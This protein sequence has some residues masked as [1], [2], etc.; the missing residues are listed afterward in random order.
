MAQNKQLLVWIIVFGPIIAL[1]LLSWFASEF[2]EKIWLIPFLL[3]MIPFIA[4]LKLGGYK[5]ISTVVAIVVTSFT[6]IVSWWLFPKGEIS[7]AIIF[8]LWI[9]VPIVVWWDRQQL[10][11]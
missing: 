10:P 4:F 7:D 6:L 8:L 2:I 1:L 3:S 11:R 9:V 5:G